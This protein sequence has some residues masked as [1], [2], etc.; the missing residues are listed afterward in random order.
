MQ[1]LIAQNV[2][3]LIPLI[4][5]A[6]KELGFLQ[7]VQTG[8]CYLISLV[9]ALMSSANR[10][11]LMVKS[12][13]TTLNSTISNKITALFLSVQITSFSV[14][15][16]VLLILL[17]HIIF[18][19]QPAQIVNSKLTLTSLLPIQHKSDGSEDAAVFFVLE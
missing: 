1:G 16:Q 10:K 5:L 17:A 9:Q 8:K 14:L 2:T 7:Q 11:L 12:S 15:I 18:S 4:V 3:A 13:F 19:I 6:I